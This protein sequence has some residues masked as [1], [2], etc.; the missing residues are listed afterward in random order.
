MSGIAYSDMLYFDDET[1]HVSGAL[2]M[3]IVSHLVHHGMDMRTLNKGLK[4]YDATKR[5]KTKK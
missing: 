2:A 3:G 1:E 5:S 4:M